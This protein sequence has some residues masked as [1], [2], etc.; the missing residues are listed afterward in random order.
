MAK[1]M[2]YHKKED[3]MGIARACGISPVLARVIR[4]RDVIG[5]EATRRYLDGTM[6][7][8]HDPYLLPDMDRAVSLLEEKIRQ[9]RA[10][11]V[12][13]DY[14]VDGI[15]ASY[16]LVT[17]LRACGAAAD[18]RLPDRISDGYGINERLVREAGDSGIDTILTCDNGIAA[19]E[20][21]GTAKETGM[22]VI[23]TD[24]HE[25]PFRLE[26]NGEKT[27]ILPPADAVVD[28]KIPSSVTGRPD[29]LF[30]DICGAAIAWKLAQALTARMQIPGRQELMKELLGFCALATVCDVMPLQDENRIMVRYGLRAAAATSNPGLRALIAVTGLTGSALTPYHAGFI[31]GPCMNATGRLDTAERALALFFEKDENRALH[32]AQELKNLNDSRK[33]MTRQGIEEACRIAPA[34][35][36]PENKV[37]VIY[38]PDCHESLAGIIAGRVRERYARPSIVLTKTEEGQ[39]KGSGRSIEAYDMFEELN[40]CKD[41]FVRFG[42]HK[43]AAGLTLQDGKV[44]VFRRRINELCTLREEDLCEVIHIDMELPLRFVDMPLTESFDRLGPFGTGNPHPLFVT[45]DVYLNGYRILGQNRNVVKLTGTVDGL[46]APEMICFGDGDEFEERI[47]REKGRMVLH[48][49]RAGRGS[50]CADIVYEPSINSFRGERNVQIRIRDMRFH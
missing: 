17:V 9:G 48:D 14:D 10:V 26:E 27:W 3:F 37:L 41:L 44:D 33:D 39:I 40:K 23:V 11:R 31:L 2:V 15:C 50:L 21:L 13:G 38:M 5:M 43:M 35:G 22:T 34:Q 29:Y 4:N 24:H 46:Q 8:L 32:A 6:D 42:G 18:A 47:L 28:P 12:I 20:P 7:M 49:L 19:A 45:R 1:W 25:V 30:R 16:I 36:Y